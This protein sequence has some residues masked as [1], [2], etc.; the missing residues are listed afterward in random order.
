MNYGDM[1]A[2]GES[3][4]I[5]RLVKRLWKD[6]IGPNAPIVFDVGANTGA[7]SRMITEA[8]P[9]A[10][11]FAF[12]PHPKTFIRLL[13][14]SLPGVECINSAVGSQIGVTLLYDTAAS[15][16]SEHASTIAGAV[17]ALN[18]RPV[19]SGEVPLVTIDSFLGR[20]GISR[21]HLLKIDVEGAELE[22]LKGA[23]EAI[24]A[25]HIDVIQFEF[26]EM[27]VTSR[28]FFRDFW[29]LLAGYSF[30]RLL[31]SGVLAIPSYRS[32][33]CELFAY[34]NILAVRKDICLDLF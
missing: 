20:R 16:G 30:Y 12:E 9:E 3:R 10:R 19:E 4:F 11:V 8:C 29:R 28:V 1:D 27:N 26:N 21:I 25:G 33:Y 18:D 17:D 24:K 14:G 15:G 7:F 22:V 13:R 6:R 34:Q 5:R 31:P 23:G 2:T 32:F